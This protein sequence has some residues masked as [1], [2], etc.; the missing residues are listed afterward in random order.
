[1]SFTIYSNGTV[2]GT[3]PGFSSVPK[4]SPFVTDM[5]TLNGGLCYFSTVN[6]ENGL[7]NGFGR[8]IFSNGQTLLCYFVNNKGNGFGVCLYGNNQVY[9]GQYSNGLYEPE[10][11]VMVHS[12]DD[13]TVGNELVNHRGIKATGTLQTVQHLYTEAVR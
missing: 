8:M 2:S 3:V 9:M 12:N 10:K 4:Y 7:Y 1:M 5:G 13:V 11:G 6:R